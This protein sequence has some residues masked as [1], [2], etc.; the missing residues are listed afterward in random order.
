MQYHYH[1]YWL[2]V[3]I[4]SPSVLNGCTRRG[5]SFG[6]SLGVLGKDKLK[7]RI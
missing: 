1:Y 6:N 4:A 2:L 7:S 3:F 5:P